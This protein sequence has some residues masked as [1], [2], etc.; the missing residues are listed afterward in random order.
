MRSIAL[1]A[2][3]PTASTSALLAFRA[4][5]PAPFPADEARSRNDRGEVLA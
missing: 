3:L 4:L 1:E 2:S 5:V